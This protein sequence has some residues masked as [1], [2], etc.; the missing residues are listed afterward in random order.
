MARSSPFRANALSRLSSPEQLDAAVRVTR[1]RAWIALTAIGLVLVAFIAWSL[2]GTV[3]STFPASGI[4]L[5]PFG[6]SNTVATHAGQVTRVLVSQ[7]DGVSAGEPVA[8][9]RTATGTTETV[10][11]SESGQVTEIL[12]YPGH[13]VAAGGPIMTIQPTGQPLR[14][15]LFVPVGS[16]QPIKTGMAVQLFVATVPSEQ[17][18]LL[19]GTVARVG[20]HPVTRVGVNAL[21]NNP[22]LTAQIFGGNPV[23]QVEVD[24]ERSSTSP[25]GYAWTSGGGP[26]A[27]VAAG[28]LASATI[29]LSTRHPISML[30]PSERQ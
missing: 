17:Y 11:A 26:S 30:F 10:T 28:T 2:F 22:D 8:A 13:P 15:F 6:T 1:P 27:Q 19:L 7:G 12:A 29:I 18:G 3:Q 4:L 14:A 25:S 21:L 5:S 23:I 20:T 24:L 16:S 9:V